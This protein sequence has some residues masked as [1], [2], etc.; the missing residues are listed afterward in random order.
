MG[1]NNALLIKEE[2]T[3]K[4]SVYSKCWSLCLWVLPETPIEGD[5]IYHAYPTAEILFLSHKG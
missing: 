4:L 5:G 3:S 1:W 2:K